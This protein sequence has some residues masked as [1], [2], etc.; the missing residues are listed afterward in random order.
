MYFS[1]DFTMKEYLES[2]NNAVKAFYS[3]DKRTP[4]QNKK[5][6]ERG[7]F[8]LSNPEIISSTNTT[9]AL[10]KIPKKG[11]EEGS[12][13]SK[14]L[15]DTFLKSDDEKGFILWEKQI[16]NLLDIANV[17]KD[18]HSYFVY[19]V[20]YNTATASGAPQ[21]IK[22]RIDSRTT[23]S[24]NSRI[25]LELNGIVST[26]DF[27]KAMPVI[28]GYQN[29]LYGMKKYK[30]VIN[31][32]RDTEIYQLHLKGLTNGEV[33]DRIISDNSI[34]DFDEFIGEDNVQKIIER[35]RERVIE[36]KRKRYG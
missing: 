7:R 31:F 35:Y 23:R 17:D 28:G 30:P 15:Q 36:T 16:Q 8:Y 11:F 27:R 29:E 18:W 20:F 12:D 25:V 3:L 5:V 26:E 1:E 32:E 10:F 33:V 4:G 13:I 14:W 22:P 19:Y 34:G 9:R 21:L 2:L 24:R 6:A